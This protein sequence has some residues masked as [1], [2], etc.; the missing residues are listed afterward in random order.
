MNS[1][2]KVLSAFKF[3]MDDHS[4]FMEKLEDVDI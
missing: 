3:A 4:L 1:D 2:Q